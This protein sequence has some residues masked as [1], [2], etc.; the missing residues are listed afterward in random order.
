MSAV[1]DESKATGS[2]RL[3]LLAIADHTEDDGTGAWPSVETLGRKTLMSRRTVQRNI[4]ELVSLGELRVVDG[5]K[6]LSPDRRPNGY[7]VRLPSLNNRYYSG[8]SDWRPG[9]YGGSPVDPL[10]RHQRPYGASP[11]APNPSLPTHEPSLSDRFT[12]LREALQNG[13]EEEDDG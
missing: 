5:P 13:C 3:L 1:W 7:E 6:H 9:A 12:G 4:Q 11:V 10:R 8:A 2:A